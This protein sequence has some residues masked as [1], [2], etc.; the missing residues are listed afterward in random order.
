MRRAS[1]ACAPRPLLCQR[2]H[3]DF[4]QS[5]EHDDCRRMA[6]VTLEGEHRAFGGRGDVVAE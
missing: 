1:I 3:L 5:F 6:V 2:D 4:D